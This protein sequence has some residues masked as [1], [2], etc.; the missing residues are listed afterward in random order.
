VIDRSALG[1]SV[2]VSVELLLPPVGSVTP[3]GAVTVAVL[4]SVP[5]SDWLMVR[6][7]RKP[8]VSPVASVPVVKLTMPVPELKVAPFVAET[9]VVPVGKR[10]LTVAPVMVLGPLLVTM[11]V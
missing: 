7:S 5:V 2:S 1:V 11:I 4:P 6:V 10:S 3:T 9:K 8:S